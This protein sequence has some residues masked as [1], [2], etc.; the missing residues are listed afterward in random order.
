MD[1]VRSDAEWPL[2][3]PVQHTEQPAAPTVTRAW[4]GH[5]APVA[6]SIYRTRRA[7][8]LWRRL[9]DRA[10][11][12]ADP[13]VLFIDRINAHNN[14]GYCES[15]SA[16]NPCAEEPLPAFGACNLGSLNLTAF[17]LDPF[18]PRAR[19][20][21]AAI[22]Q[23]ARVAVRFLD[24][25][26]DITHFP[27]LRQRDQAHHSRRL[28]LG[29][30]GLADA[31]AMLALPYDT[32]P[33][34]QTTATVMRA[35]RD[36]AYATSVQLARERGPFPAFDRGKYPERPFILGLPTPLQA[37]IGRYGMRNSHLLAIAPTGTI[38]LLAGNISS[39]IEPIFG[40]EMQRRVLDADG[41]PRNFLIA[42]YAYAAWRATQRGQ[43]RLGQEFRDSATI[44]ARD[45]LL[46]QA[47]LQPYVDGAIAKT[48]MLSPAATAAGVVQ[49]FEDAYDLDLKG[50]TVFREA[51]RRGVIAGPYPGDPGQ[52]ALSVHCCDVGRESD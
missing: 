47:A 40:L 9:C 3:F 4:S 20:D 30:S 43:G 14:L 1:A 38:S 18:T 10:Y 19:F 7:R 49:T 13:G 24:N 5:P 27:L 48:V 51:A 17:V 42:D 37:D 26:I 50:C 44:S 46:M 34:R 41:T 31:L 11:A 45:H 29:I 23:T 28:G 21:H 15:I 35:I 32:E 33:A 2:V 25:V 16:T 8:E 39:G 6:C 36:A 52:K 12:S 22:E